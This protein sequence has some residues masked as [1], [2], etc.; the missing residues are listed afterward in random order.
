MLI[1]VAAGIILRDDKVFIALR[2][3]SQHQGGLWEFPGGK[4]EPSESACVTL[5]RELKEECGI[6][7]TDYE[8]FKEISHDYDDKHVELLFYKVTGFDGEPIGKEGQEVCWVP[9]PELLS[10]KF[11]EANQPI[12]IELMT[13]Q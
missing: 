12:V 5:L 2:K 13:R 10:Y 11:P 9:I 4:C 7:I 6:S 3:L 1:K 8:F